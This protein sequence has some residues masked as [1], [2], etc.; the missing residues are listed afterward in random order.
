MTV[1]AD[2]GSPGLHVGLNACAGRTRHT[3]PRP[4]ACF[5]SSDRTSLPAEPNL[6]VCS[7]ACFS[8][9]FEDFETTKAF[10]ILQRQRDKLLCC[11][12]RAVLPCAVLLWQ[13]R[14]VLRLDCSVHSP[15]ISVLAVLIAF[16]HCPCPCCPRFLNL[17]PPIPHPAAPLSTPASQR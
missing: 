13:D 11:E 10:E 15:A 7:A 5:P 17:L 2:E 1:A 16:G 4:A 8:P 3:A 14:T 9:Q 6:R 12:R